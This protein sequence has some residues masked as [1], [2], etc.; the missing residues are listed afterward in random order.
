MMKNTVR[1]N[2][3]ILV[4]I[5]LTGHMKAGRLPQVVGETVWTVSMIISLTEH[6][7]Q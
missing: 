5:Y 6:I 3:E 4:E 2:Q 1:V 7:L